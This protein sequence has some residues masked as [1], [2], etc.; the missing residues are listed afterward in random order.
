MFGLGWT[1]PLSPF[2]KVGQRTKPPLCLD[3][4]GQNPLHH[5]TGDDKTPHILTGED[6]TP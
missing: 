4:G 6:E 3:W 5:L 1:K 2:N